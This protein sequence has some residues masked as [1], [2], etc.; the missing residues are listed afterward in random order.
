M[1]AHAPAASIPP[2][3]P[4]APRADDT[5]PLFDPAR[6]RFSRFLECEP[7]DRRMLIPDFLPLEI[8]G[9]LASMGGAG[10]SVLLY[11]LAM[12]IATGAPFLGMAIEEVGSVLVVAAEDDEPELHRR[13][14]RIL[15]AYEAHSSVDRG[16]L[17]ERLHIES[18]VAAD[19]MLTA[20][21]EG[22]VVR[23]RLVD[24]LVEAAR[25][26]PDLKLIVLD[27]VSRFRGGRANAEEDVTRFVE[28]LE[29][30][31]AATAATV[32]AAVHVNKASIRDGAEADQSIV[33]GSTALVDGVRWCATLQRLR[34]DAAADYGINAAEADRYVRFDLAKANYVAPWPGL[35]LRREAGG[36]LV[37]TSLEGAKQSK[38]EQRIEARYSS[39]LAAIGELVRSEGPM[40]RNRI[41]R[42][43]TGEL[44]SLGAGQKAVR[45]VI[46]RAVRDGDLVE[47][48][49]TGRGGGKVIDLPGGKA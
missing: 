10:K 41:E 49:N 16:A 39:I 20:G 13:G 44:G 3:I 19:N 48:D 4:R 11:Q 26:I 9:L 31:R 8:V 27:P 5:P 6:I 43:H 32:L 21:R 7:P 1:S 22:E 47:R 23:T 28:V 38:A 2:E 17:G 34:R 37:Q 42:E 15:D 36:V 40:S 46:N 12:S 45:D 33:R 30:I 35:W 25:L 24:Q 14:R 18:R 29:A